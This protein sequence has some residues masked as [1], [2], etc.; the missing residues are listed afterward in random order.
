MRYAYCA[1]RWQQIT[2]IHKQM[3]GLHLDLGVDSM[4]KVFYRCVISIIAVAPILIA[5]ITRVNA[6]DAESRAWVLWLK[7]SY[8]IDF[9]EEAEEWT[10]ISAYPKHQDCT[11]A[12]DRAWRSQLDV[13]L[14]SISTPRGDRRPPDIKVVQGEAIIVSR[15]D[16]DVVAF[17]TYKYTC[18][19]DTVNPRKQ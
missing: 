3:E 14:R 7:N 18:L 15:V 13:W 5:G 4:L 10:I 17:I 16:A 1:L 19:P 8:M 12:K 2:L 6:A 9:K 11:S